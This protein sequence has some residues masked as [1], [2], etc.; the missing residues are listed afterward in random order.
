MFTGSCFAEAADG[1]GGVG[2][3]ADG[4]GAVV[5][6]LLVDIAGGASSVVLVGAGAAAPSPGV[7]VLSSSGVDVV[8]CPSVVVED[9]VEGPGEACKV[10][11]K[12]D[13]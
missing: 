13:F 10:K 8:L 6:P 4:G 5:S 7:T 11:S 2:F 12:I 1:A 3:T 9:V